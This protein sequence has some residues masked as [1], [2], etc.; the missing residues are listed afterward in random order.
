VAQNA[1]RN[2]QHN[3]IRVKITRRASLMDSQYVCTG[4]PTVD[5][6]KASI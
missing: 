2:R 4:G 1:E 6:F 3:L 5:R